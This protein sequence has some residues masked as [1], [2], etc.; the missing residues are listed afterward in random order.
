MSG[1]IK[2]EKKIAQEYDWLISKNFLREYMMVC[3]T[4]IPKLD[5]SVKDLV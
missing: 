2:D 3:V 1:S 4:D 5:D